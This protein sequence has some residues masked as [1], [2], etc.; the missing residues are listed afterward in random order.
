MKKL[1]LILI[2]LVPSTVFGASELERFNMMGRNSPGNHFQDPENRELP[3]LS[4]SPFNENYAQ[5][6]DTTGS[7]TA[8][9]SRLTGLDNTF[10]GATGNFLTQNLYL[11]VPFQFATNS[12][13]NEGLI[14]VITGGSLT[15]LLDITHGTGKFGVL[16]V[17]DKDNSVTPAVTGTRTYTVGSK[18]LFKLY[19]DMGATT[20]NGVFTL[21]VFD[22]TSGVLLETLSGSGLDFGD[23]DGGQTI[24]TVYM[25]RVIGRGGHLAGTWGEG[26]ASADGFF[27]NGAKSVWMK[28]STRTSSANG[29]LVF[30]TTDYAEAVKEYDSKN[31]SEGKYIYRNTSGGTGVGTQI[32][33]GFEGSDGYNQ[34]GSASQIYGVSACLDGWSDS[35]GSASR[36]QIV[37]NYKGVDYTLTTP[38]QMN[39]FVLGDGGY[40]HTRCLGYFDESAG[41]YNAPDG[42]PWD[43][44]ALKN[45]T[46]GTYITNDSDGVNITS[47]MI[48]VYLQPNASTLKMSSSGVLKISSSGSLII[49]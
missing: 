20:G 45:S 44:T 23:F 15:R 27:P 6:I 3:P 11:K 48:G 49:R 42:L 36:Y 25:G 14:S 24:D 19:M 1:L 22:F 8:S 46:L 18:V 12:F 28:A 40:P 26:V 43:K 13:T 16:Q 30:G 39:P 38:T 47:I 7:Y 29:W 4:T 35:A 17:Y 5:T 32:T 10:F 21:Q 2:I 33:Y 9:S 41:V 34:I 37:F 31:G